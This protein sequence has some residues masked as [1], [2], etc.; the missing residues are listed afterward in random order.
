MGE[1]AEPIDAPDFTPEEA[2]QAAV[3]LAFP[4]F[5]QLPVKD[6]ANVMLMPARSLCLKRPR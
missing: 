2:H 4:A 6:T 1:V 3:R 5:A